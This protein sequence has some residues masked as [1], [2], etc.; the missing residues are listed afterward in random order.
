MIIFKFEK[1]CKMN[2]GA[3]APLSIYH[4]L[5]Q[6]TCNFFMLNGDTLLIESAF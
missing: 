3:F 1:P 5:P 4:K 6:T 2:S